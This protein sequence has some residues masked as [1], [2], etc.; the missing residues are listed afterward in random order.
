MLRGPKED[1]ARFLISWIQ[2][3]YGA[4]LHAEAAAPGGVGPRHPGA[5]KVEVRLPHEPNARGRLVLIFECDGL[6]AH[7]VFVEPSYQGL[8]RTAIARLTER[9]GGKD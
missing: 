4:S 1:H 3:L 6:S 7:V 8:A 2:N 9:F 5:E